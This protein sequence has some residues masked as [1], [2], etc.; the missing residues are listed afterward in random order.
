MV[1]LPGRLAESSRP[2]SLEVVW[3][4]CTGHPGL[5]G[6]AGLDETSATPVAATLQCC[7]AAMLQCGGTEGRR[8]V[9]TSRD[10]RD[11]RRG[12]PAEECRF[13]GGTTMDLD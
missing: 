8:D 11:Q 5:A 10:S 3:P 1:T 2:W 12:F 6:L 13:R 4:G 9:G 7:S